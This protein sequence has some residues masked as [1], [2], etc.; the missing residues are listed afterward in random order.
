MAATQTIV[1]SAKVGTLVPR[2]SLRAPAHG[3]RNIT[4]A[5][6]PASTRASAL[7]GWSSVVSQSG[8]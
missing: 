6:A 2:T 3:A 7:S 8:K 1:V 5:A 4:N